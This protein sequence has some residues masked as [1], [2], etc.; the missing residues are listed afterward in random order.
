MKML[1]TLGLIYLSLVLALYLFQ[2]KLQ[3]HPLKEQV[4]PSHYGLTHVEEVS[5]DTEDGE[6]INAWHAKAKEGKATF[7]YFHGNAEAI[8]QRWERVR[9][10]TEHG[11]GILIVSYRGFAGSTGSPTEAGLHLDAK[12]A[13]R[14]LE[15]QGLAPRDLIYF[16]ESLGSGVAIPLAAKHPPAAIVLDSPFTSAADV[17]QRAYWFVPTRYLMKDKFN[18]MAHVEKITS[19]VFIFH[20]DADRIVPISF[21]QKLYEAFTSPKE[22]LRLAGLGH[23]EPLTPLSWGKMK[24]FLEN[25]TGSP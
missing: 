25:H 22:F 24:E 18:N 16:G 1:Y 23:V 20:G 7:L 6:S 17:G 15:V 3:Y 4:S 12:A 2:R 14:F 9:L 10:F 11:Y 21:G 8:Q 5:F 13:L 19:P